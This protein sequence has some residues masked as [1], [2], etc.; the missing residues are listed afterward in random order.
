MCLCVSILLICFSYSLCYI[1]CSWQVQSNVSV[2]S[3]TY[4]QKLW[5]SSLSSTPR[6]GHTPQGVARH[7]GAVGFL[8]G[9]ASARGPSLR[10]SQL[11]HTV[12][13]TGAAASPILL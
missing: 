3:I 13:R 6:A 9:S 2:H 10:R 8:W 5:K 11:A 1:L 7:P 12:C 4:L